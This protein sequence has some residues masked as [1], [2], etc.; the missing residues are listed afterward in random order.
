MMQKHDIPSR[1][2][3][4]P[5]KK[6]L[7]LWAVVFWLIVWEL[8]AIWVAEPILLVTPVAA[9]RRLVELVQEAAFWKSIAFSVGHI[10]L[11]FGLSALLGVGLAALAYR[12]HLVRELLAPLTAAVKAIPVASFVILVLLWVS[13]RDLSIIISLLIGFPVIYANVLM[14][15]D[16]TD[17][18]LI[19][20]AKVFRV[21][22]L[23]Q[24]RAIYLYQVLPFLRSGLAV[25]I[26]LCWKSGVAAEVIGIPKG[27]IGENLYKAKVYLETPDLFC[28]TLVIVLLSIACEKL[29]ALLMNWVEKEA[30][31]CWKR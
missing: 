7:P 30:S 9:L 4:K 6:R 5:S 13:S 29:L 23:T 15:L 28:W 21:P 11:G 14:G 20:M 24:L 12:F 18:K 8:L 22:F 10:L 1:S 27:S 17:P 25:A 31:A 2:G 19:E 26:G 3:A 16:S